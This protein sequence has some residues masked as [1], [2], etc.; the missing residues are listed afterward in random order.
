MAARN[1]TVVL[2]CAVRRQTRKL[3][4]IILL[5]V[6]QIFLE[7]WESTYCS[8]LPEGLTQTHAHSQTTKMLGK[9]G[10]WWVKRIRGCGRTIPENSL[11]RRKES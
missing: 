9:F 2:V 7:H 1:A 3:V 5:S 10:A 6:V 8:A 4:V 11:K